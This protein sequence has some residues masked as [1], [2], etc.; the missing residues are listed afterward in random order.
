VTNGT[1]RHAVVNSNILRSK[2]NYQFTQ[3]FSLRFIAQYN[4]LLA[5]PQFSSLQTVKNMN[6][7][8]LFTY[9]PHPG[10]AVYIGYNS[11]LE[12]VCL[13]QPSSQTCTLD[14][15]VLFRPPNRFTNDGRQLFIKLSYLF[16]R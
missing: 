7:D 13:S 16:R 14:G 11:N 12:N 5:N 6:F 3:A 1:L 2:W 10:T 4:G 9:L 8:V 15:T